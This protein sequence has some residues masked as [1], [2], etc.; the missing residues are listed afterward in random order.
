MSRRNAV[1]LIAA[2]TLAAAAVIWMARDWS[3]P[4]CAPSAQTYSE[5]LGQIPASHPGRGHSDYPG[6][7]VADIPKSYAMVLAAELNRLR[8]GALP[9][10]DRSLIRTAGQWLLD[11]CDEDGD[12]IVGW[13]LPF[14]WDAYG[15]GTT[16]PAHTE[17]TITTG[18][19][20]NALLDWADSDFDAPQGRIVATVSRALA[21]YLGG[22][23]VSPSG[24]FA[25]S[26][27][28][29]DLHYDCF[30]PAAYLAGQMQRFSHYVADRKLQARTRQASDR[31]MGILLAHRKTDPGGGW[32]WS[33]S[34]QESNV[35]NDLP[36]ASYII[37]GIRHY[38][39]GGGALSPSFDWEAV[40]GHLQTFSSKDH[41]RWHAFPAFSGIDR[42]RPPRL[43]DL[44]MA[45]YLFARHDAAPERARALASTICSYGA[46]GGRY[47]KWPRSSKPGREAGGDLIIQEYEAY[48][49]MGL[50][51]YCFP[52]KPFSPGQMV[53]GAGLAAGYVPVPLTFFETPTLRA[54]LYFDADRLTGILRVNGKQWVALP[55]RTLPMKLVEW[56]PGHGLLLS[57]ELW[58]NR[59]QCHS[60]RDGQT[61]LEAL[62][63]PPDLGTLLF[64]QAVAFRDRLVVIAY[65]ST[66]NQNILF[67]LAFTEPEKRLI[68]KESGR[69]VLL[70]SADLGYE[71]QPHIL[72]A[73]RNG[74][75]LLAGGPSVY[76]I[77]PGR[78]PDRLELTRIFFNRNWRALEL[79]ASA[80]NAAVLFQAP[81]QD[82]RFRIYDLQSKQT[83]R[84]FDGEQIPFHL[85]DE[86]GPVSARVVRT[87]ADLE[88]L[89][90]LDVRNSAAS[91][92]MSAGLNN[93]EGEVV[94]SQSYYLNGFVDFFDPSLYPEP[95]LPLL[96]VRNEIAG[97][98]DLEMKLLDRLLSE[99]PGLRCRVFSTNREPA[100]YAVQSG[101]ILLLLKRYRTVTRDRIAL[102]S[103]DSFLRD[104][105]QLRGHREVL[106]RSAEGGSDSTRGLP[107]LMWPKGIPFPYDGAG[108]PYNH[109]NCWAAGILYRA[110]RY[111]VPQET[112]EAARGIADFFLTLEGF[113]G[114]PPKHDRRFEASEDYF[115]WYYWWGKAKTGWDSREGVSAN[116]PTW[117]GDGENIAL[118]RYRTFDAIAVLCA[119]AYK[120]F[121][122][123]SLLSYFTS[124]VEGDGLELFLLP[125]LASAE[126]RPSI[127]R[128]LAIRYLRVDSQPD[129]RNAMLAYRSLHRDLRSRG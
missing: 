102:G 49:L 120:P 87:P 27:D 58:T 48:L 117:R 106:A 90:L 29:N 33:Y 45:L 75:L 20:V 66:R 1:L 81:S 16:N 127:C 36:H 94:W 5:L 54:D 114:N 128:A 55:P 30:N 51:Y 61:D 63:L 80:R 67:D 108:V 22:R 93:D 88:A 57:R 44:G 99:G 82:E 103:F 8:A 40:Y 42:D 34:L 53:S 25:Y 35:P 69:Q 26:L 78:D 41:S 10:R 126:K 86:A 89:F 12:G 84:T 31:V 2:A 14:A 43:Y 122:D 38:M 19:V 76:S 72:A 65:D 112:A 70:L 37:D 111:P 60:V 123:P 100:R 3:R 32:Y 92:L 47:A 4:A 125:Y 85:N 95:D 109:Q 83:V 77:Q 39:D 59:W 56:E 116:T 79:L 121:V 124:A 110:D 17:Y 62:A 91:G 28:A 7:P 6:N 74:A 115:R 119:H 24:L 64:R 71:Q 113:R 104:T 50:S 107:Y 105:A 46:D 15:D 9:E 23:F 11:H 73:V 97:R 98:L 129:Y 21:P 52:H 13:G 101:K 118:P 18:I 96:R 68:L